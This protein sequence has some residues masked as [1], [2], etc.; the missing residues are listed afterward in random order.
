MD[1]YLRSGGGNSPIRPCPGLPTTSVSPKI[2]VSSIAAPSTRV[3]SVDPGP[4]RAPQTAIVAQAD[5]VHVL[6]SKTRHSHD[7]ACREELNGIGGIGVPSRIP[8]R[9][10]LA[11]GSGAIKERECAERYL[12]VEA[13][14]A[15]DDLLDSRRAGSDYHSQ[16]RRPLVRD[17]LA[18][19]AVLIQPVLC[20][21][22]EAGVEPE[23]VR[24]R[25]G[26]LSVCGVD[27]VGDVRLVLNPIPDPGFSPLIREQVDATADLAP[28]LVHPARKSCCSRTPDRA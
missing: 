21:P 26:V 24:D 17:A 23:P 14:R 19:H 28:P 6:A 20:L 27:T 1:R 16:P 13:A 25:P 5:L 8:R 7:P 3:R 9:V 22:P 2:W 10:G 11:E 18:D 15:G 12:L 4:D